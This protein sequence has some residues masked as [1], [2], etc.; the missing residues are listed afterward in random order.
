VRPAELVEPAV[1]RAEPVEPANA[2]VE[3]EP[4]AFTRNEDNVAI[5]IEP[6]VDEASS[7]DGADL[8]MTY[9]ER[10]PIGRVVFLQHAKTQGLDTP[11]FWRHPPANNRIPLDAILDETYVPR[12]EDEGL[13]GYV[14]SY[15]RRLRETTG[16]TAIELRPTDDAEP[17]LTRQ[18]EPRVRALS[19]Q[20]DVEQCGQNPFVQTLSVF[21]PLVAVKKDTARYCSPDAFRHAERIHICGDSAMVHH[22]VT[23][24]VRA[25]I[26]PRLIVVLTNLLF[27]GTGFRGQPGLNFAQA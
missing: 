11:A 10:E 21:Q 3:P 23:S 24:L 9:L 6:F 7:R 26:S 4:A 2:A 12:A 1:A 14:K 15:A 18:L 20:V 13:R 5:V 22:S 19:I 25:G 27:C 17:Y 8:F 16:R